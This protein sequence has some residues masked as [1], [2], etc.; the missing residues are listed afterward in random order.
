MPEDPTKK[1]TASNSP[2]LSDKQLESTS[3]GG[4]T[5]PS[6]KYTMF[7]PDGTPV[8]A[9]SQSVGIHAEQV[10]KLKD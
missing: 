6:I 7:N 2:E 1:S 9:E 4:V 3:G 8:R 10:E 5:T